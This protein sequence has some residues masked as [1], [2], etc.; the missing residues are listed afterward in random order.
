MISKCK[1]EKYPDIGSDDNALEECLWAI[2]LWQKIFQL[3]NGVQPDTDQ[4][5]FPL[6]ELWEHQQPRVPNLQQDFNRKYGPS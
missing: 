1:A 4:F 2:L 6:K 5:P 3:N